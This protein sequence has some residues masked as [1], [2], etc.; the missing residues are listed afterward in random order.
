MPSLT[1][2]HDSDLE[3]P[4]LTD[5]ETAVVLLE[6]P[7]AVVPLPPNHHPQH[8]SGS[9]SPKSMRDNSNA[10]VSG[11]ATNMNNDKQDATTSQSFG[12]DQDA[13]DAPSDDEYPGLN[14]TNSTT[15]SGYDSDETFS[16]TMSHNENDAAM[17]TNYDSDDTVSDPGLE[18]KY[19]Y[20]G[21][22][23]P[24][25]I[26][27]HDLEATISDPVLVNNQYVWE[28]SLSAIFDY[29]S[30]DTISDPE[31]DGKYEHVRNKSGL[32]ITN[33]DSEKPNSIQSIFY[34]LQQSSSAATAHLRV[35]KNKNIVKVKRISEKVISPR[36]C[37][38]C[39]QLGHVCT[40]CPT[41][42]CTYK[43]CNKSGHVFTNCPK[44]RK[45]KLKQSNK[46]QRV[47]ESQKRKERKAA[48]TAMKD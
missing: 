23:F 34:G 24:S 10:K 22:R 27:N 11:S 8:E 18:N 1:P 35:D 31:L 21:G 9:G 32:L 41:I 5:E 28:T 29:D 40:A 37:T 42:S 46:R 14:E 43:G 25:T 13:A 2:S 16:G 48:R 15:F 7:N 26:F 3:E 4:G 30:D 20:E 36:H 47:Y 17:E 45:H 6:L 33:H 19:R 44:R 39:K 12:Y 38:L